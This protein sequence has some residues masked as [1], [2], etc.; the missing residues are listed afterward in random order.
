MSSTE[1]IRS[2]RVT[3]RRQLTP[4]IIELRLA[5]SDGTALPP[6]QAGA[7]IDLRL[8]ADMVRQYSL[9]EP[10]AESTEWVVAVLIEQDGRGGSKLIEK[11]L[12]VGASVNA[13]GPRNHF[14]VVDADS[15][16][17]VAGGIGVTPMIGMC[18]AAER[19]GVPWRLVYL[20]RSRETMA[21]VAQ[22]QAEFPEHVEVYAS[23]DGQRFDVD[24]ALASLDAGT[25]VY[26]CGPDRLM[27]AVEAEMSGP[28]RLP[29]LHLEHFHPKDAASTENEEFTVYAAAS[30]IE[31]VVPTD[32]SILMAADFAGVV[33]PGDCMEGTCGSCET[34]VLL[35]DVEHRDSILRPQDRLSSRTMMICVSRAKPGCDRLELDL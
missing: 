15:Y 27:A 35:G 19:R 5:S 29:F 14:P 17:F 32:E 8:G 20:G 10:D 6:W 31:F 11:N 4:A 9:V 12:Q 30:D 3:A 21:Y 24:E 7:H 1:P 25:R 26:C 28:D 2:L 33:V 34:R 18:R 16:L 22:L 23:S 13:S